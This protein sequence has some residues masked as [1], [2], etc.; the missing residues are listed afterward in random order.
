MRK[1]LLLISLIL[2]AGLA[3]RLFRLGEIPPGLTHDEANHGREAIEILDGVL[4]YYFPL[5]YGSEPLYSYTV[6]GAMALLGE[7]IFALRL[8]NVIFGLAAIVAT[9][10][11]ARRAF[12][13]ATALVA[14]GL[15]AVSFWPIASSREALRAGMLPFFMV[16]A[17]WFFWQIVCTPCGDGSSAANEHRG[18]PWH[19]ATGRTAGLVLGFALS[20]VATFHIYLAARV[21]WFLFPL[22]LLY[23]ALF[24]KS[25]F[26]RTWRPA[27]AGLL[28]A[29]LLLLPM[30]IYL[31]KNPYAQTRLSM[32]SG[33]LQ[34]VASGKILPIMGNAAEALLAF[35]WPG[36]GDH[37]LAYNI[38]GRPVFDTIT[39]LFFL[40]GLVVSLRRWRQP[41][42]AFLLLW[43][44]TGI[45]PS[46]VTGSTA[47]TTRNL[48]AL[49]A[50]YLLPAVGFVFVADIAAKRL[51]LSQRAVL[52]SGAVLWFLFVALVSARDYFVRWGESADVRGAYQHTL[53]EELAY[54]DGRGI[55]EEPV[56]LSTVYPGPAHDASVA[57]V[58]AGENSAGYRWIDARSALLL[59][60][61]DETYAVIP[62]STPLHEAFSGYL[63]QLDTVTLRPD[64]LDPRFSLYAL[65]EGQDLTGKTPLGDFGSAVQLID[66]AWLTPRAKPGES[67]ELLTTWRVTDPDKIGPD[68]PPAF[69]PD[70]V[71]FTHLLDDAG[72]I[73]SQRDAL[74]APS[75][76]WQPG[77]TI[78]QVHRLQLPAGLQGGA[79]HPSIG[80]YDGQTGER[81]PLYDGSGPTAETVYAGPALEV[82]QLSK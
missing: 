82:A 59:P 39:A 19:I 14:A 50:V 42:Y 30:F 60:G 71:F 41:A 73:V 27:L 10:V 34:L 1:T 64:D 49:P 54:L 70:T 46:L 6:A 35:F 61:G 77:D 68:H 26:R 43:F 62:S 52:T 51:N 9:A 3:L 44:A 18:R 40:I 55:A 2:L 38:P 78:L 45:I 33:T 56:V 47:N 21:A 66:A 63:E 29:G 17:V 32:L 75:W 57:L 53:V 69:Q 7:N 67:V 5:N 65:S 20:I 79:Y 28:L 23:L 72:N 37:F 74:D 15:L 12:D 36:F 80:I 11:W 76:S 48:A 16:L 8:V 24:H 31:A 58:V 81:V 22:F 4:R 13:R 25:D